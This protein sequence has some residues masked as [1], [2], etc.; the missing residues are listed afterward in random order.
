M[1]T[2]TNI[3]IKDLRSVRITPYM[4]LGENHG[5]ASGDILDANATVA[6]VEKKIAEVVGG[7]RSSSD[8]L[9]EIETTM[10]GKQDNIA[11]LQ[12]VREGAAAGATAIQE[13]QDITGVTYILPS[14]SNAS[15]S[16]RTFQ[17]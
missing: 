8:T 15:L 16:T 7:A 2:N 4:E 14:S 17:Y 6:L 12:T 11:D 13:H 1:K 5:Y 9:K 10:N 3:S